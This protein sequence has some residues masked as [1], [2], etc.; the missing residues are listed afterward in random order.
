MLSYDKKKLKD[1]NSLCWG[2]GTFQML[3]KSLNKILSQY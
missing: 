3:K 2:E 1:N